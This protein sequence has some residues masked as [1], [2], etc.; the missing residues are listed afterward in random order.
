MA[1]VL[2][3]LEEL[4]AFDKAGLS[5]PERRRALQLSRSIYRQLETPIEALVRICWVDQSYI[6][7]LKICKDLGVFDVLGD[8]KPRYMS[9]ADITAAVARKTEQHPDPAF[10]VR[11][12]RHLAAQGAVLGQEADDYAATPLSEALRGADVSSG[13]EVFFNLVVPTFSAMPTHFAITDYQEPTRGDQTC[14]QF[15]KRTSLTY[16]GYLQEHP[17]EMECFMNFM[18]GY[19]AGRGVWTDIYPFS[20][21]V[22]DSAE[23]EGTLVVDVGGGK[24]HDMTKLRELYPMT[25]GRLVVQD[26]ESV[27]SAADKEE[28]AGVQMTAHDFFTPQPIFGKQF[29]LVLPQA[30]PV[31][32]LI[33]LLGA[34]VY[35]LHFILHDWSDEDSIRI[36]LNLRPAMKPEYSKLIINETIISST[37]VDPSR[38]GLDLCMMTMFATRERSQKDWTVLLERAGFKVTGT[39]TDTSRAYESVIEAEVT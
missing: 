20:S 5:T 1:Q 19:S 18:K 8:S 16:F 21:R 27:V 12:L 22:F 17:K 23:K 10:L 14:W 9:V 28:T 33:L 34:R 38:T 29:S 6:A 7:A 24:G 26:L 39:W 30:G 3:T 13:L 36:L 37:E 35:F 15:G 4:A 31:V 32:V 2:T 25:S 11:I